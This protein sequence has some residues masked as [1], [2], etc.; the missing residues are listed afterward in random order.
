VV[1][2][3]S[4]LLQVRA[5]VGAGKRKAFGSQDVGSPAK[6]RPL[7]Q[8][9]SSSSISGLHLN[10]RQM[11]VLESFRRA[12]IQDIVADVSQSAGRSHARVNG[13]CSTLTPNSVTVV[14]RANRIVMPIEKLLLHGFPIHR[15][16]IPTSTGSSVLA[17]LGGNTM[18]VKSV[19]LAMLIG[20]SLVNWAHTGAH[21]GAKADADMPSS[22]PAAFPLGGV[23][24]E[25]G[26]SRKKVRQPKA[27]RKKATVHTSRRRREG[28]KKA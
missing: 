17:S 25:G 6:K 7:A 24:Q 15:M 2:S 11:R 23:S 8:S 22:P 1:I 4:P 9:S 12:G 10:P 26:G 16:S 21:S 14:E 18:H 3:C 5:K 19:G 27:I 28:V 13:L 20:I